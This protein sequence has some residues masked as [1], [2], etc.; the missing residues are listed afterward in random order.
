MYIDIT[1]RRIKFVLGLLFFAFTVCFAYESG[2]VVHEQKEMTAKEINQKI[3]T[4]CLL[5]S[6]RYEDTDAV[7]K[8]CA[9]WKAEGYL[10]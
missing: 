5:A 2:K 8:L 1:K 6:K 9:R 10:E 7:N 4:E 3:K